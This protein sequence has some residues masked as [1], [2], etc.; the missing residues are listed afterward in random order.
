MPTQD[1]FWLRVKYSFFS[2][3][4]FLLVTNPMTLKLLQNIFGGIFQQE[5]LTPKGYF[6]QVALFFL[7]VL[8]LMMFPKDRWFPCTKSNHLM[9]FLFLE[10]RYFCMILRIQFTPT[11]HFR[12]GVS[13]CSNPKGWLCKTRVTAFHRLILNPLA[14]HISPVLHLFIIT[15][16]F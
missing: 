6:I 12:F 15:P 10:H 8:A 7:T 5:G 11:F 4:V 16:I 3:L 9:A 13:N 2:A 1:E 14:I